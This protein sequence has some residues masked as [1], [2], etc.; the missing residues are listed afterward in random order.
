MNLEMEEV[1]VEHSNNVYPAKTVNKV[2]VNT[3]YDADRIVIKNTD[4]RH[5]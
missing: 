5:G 1:R 3:T 2:N 4:S